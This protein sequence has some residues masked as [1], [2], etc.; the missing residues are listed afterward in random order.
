MLTSGTVGSSIESG[1]HGVVW[2]SFT[3]ESIHGHYGA[4]AVPDK[5]YL[6]TRA[7]LVVLLDVG[8]EKVGL[9]I[10]S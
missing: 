6:S 2:S 3:T 8:V 5:S 10:S 4:G 7:G 1:D 9:K